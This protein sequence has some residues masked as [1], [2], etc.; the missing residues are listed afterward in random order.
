VVA[1]S[2]EQPSAAEIQAWIISYLSD[3]LEIP[4]D[5]IDTREPLASYGIDSTGAVGMVGDLGAWLDRKLDPE[6]LYSY[7]TIEALT[8]RLVGERSS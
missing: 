7:P 6:V 3:L 4:P 2:N 1:G 5:E 8:R